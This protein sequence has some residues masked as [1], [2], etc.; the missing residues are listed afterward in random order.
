MHAE[1]HCGKTGAAYGCASYRRRDLEAI[2]NK[3]FST[4]ALTKRFSMRAYIKQS[5]QR[6]NLETQL[7][8]TIA[9]P[10]HD[11]A[12]E[13]HRRASRRITS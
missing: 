13:R 5:S 12:I 2:C 4:T 7:R 10:A 1:R 3:R 6:L 11:D 9:G 8:A